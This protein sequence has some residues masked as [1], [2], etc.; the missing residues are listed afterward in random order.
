M[1]A[2]LALAA[3][4]ESTK[5]I[6]AGGAGGAA[7]GIG[8]TLTCA[9][10][11]TGTWITM[12]TAGAPIANPTPGL[13]WTGSDL[14]SYHNP[15]LAPAN[16]A[17]FYA[18]C[19]DTWRASPAPAAHEQYTAPIPDA[20]L[21]LFF[22]PTWTPPM[23]VGLDYRKNLQPNL[24]LTGAVQADFAAIASTGAKLIA[25]GG[26]IPKTLPEQTGWNGTQ[27]G[28]IY[29]PARDSWQAMT[30][31]GAPAARVA[32]AV[33]TGSSFVVWGGSSAD[34]Y[35]KGQYRYDCATSAHADLGNDCTVFGDGAIYDP[36]R[37]AWTAMNAAGAP[38][39]RFDHLIA[40]AGDRVLIWG[41]GQQ[42]TPDPVLLT[43]AKQWLS[44]GGLYDPASRIWTATATAP[45][46]VSGF[47]LSAYW[48][49]WTGDR[50]AVGPNGSA[51][52]WL[53][54]PHKD[55]WSTL[56]APAD[57]GGSCERFAPQAGAL[58]ALCRIAQQRSVLLLL[59]GETDWRTYPLPS[60]VPTAP[61][62]LWTGKRLFIWGGTV[63]SSFVCPPSSQVGCDP[64]PPV[65]S[66]AGWV[67]VP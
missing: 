18:P 20:G 5:V 32:P 58:V 2:S 44:D 37:D 30:T 54:D 48:Q 14:Y 40:W 3:C 28:A 7:V 52:G 43:P 60:G 21:L 27:Y 9:L 51:S 33:W 11:P 35:M 65:Y 55:R 61:G 8:D 4:G 31:V 12:S 15:G 66:N 53:Y 17:A 46:P 10:Q 50:L 38:R 34:T 41:G 36:A 67:L 47:E 45:L 22:G 16:G 6:G 1:A 29:D 39:A 25:W 62:M 19:S 63:A 23:F 26:A 49:H 56:T 42:G 24:S 13:F 57:F 59:P 64:P